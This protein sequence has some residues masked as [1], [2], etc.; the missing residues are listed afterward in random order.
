MQE[1]TI[2]L[3]GGRPLYE[4]IYEYLKSEI[5]TGAMKAADRLPSSRHLAEHLQVSR[6][7]VNMAYEQLASEG[8]IESRRGSGYFVTGL[9]GQLRIPAA[10]ADSRRKTLEA[11]KTMKVDFSPRGIDVSTFPRRTWGRLSRE[12][13]GGEN[14]ELFGNGMSQGEPALRRAICGYLHAARGV[15]CSEDRVV[16]GAGN[17]YLLMLLHQILGSVTVAMEN[18]T[19]K[20]AWRILSGMGCRMEPVEM[21]AWG[22][23]TD[24]LNRTEA[25]IVYVMPSHQYPTGIVMPIKR[26]MELLAWAGSAEGRFVI[27]D[28]YDSEFRYKGKP[29]PSLQGVDAA[30]RVIYLGT[31][32]RSIAPAIRVSYMVLPEQL[33]EVYREKCGFYA[34][35]VSRVDQ[36]ILARFLSEGYFERHLNK[37]RALYRNKH[38]ILLQSLKPL[39]KWFVLRGEHAG[40]HLLLQE[41]P[42]LPFVSEQEL[43]GAA[44]L[45]GVRVYGL[46]GYEI[47]SHQP[48]TVL[49][50][51]ANLSQ[52]EIREGAELL[53]CAWGRVFRGN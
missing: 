24:L 10:P 42:E 53:A 47:H 48:S 14:S 35:T 4:Q 1:L 2:P 15:N 51:Y 23:R 39:E 45:E 11:E 49:L 30:D 16:I 18:P 13:L 20:Q 37:A 3:Q 46:S 52:Q 28:D 50:G 34:S 25:Q 43:I 6:S 26:R 19:Y 32:S 5:Q 38:E 40:L 22:M 44:E 21:D 7:T 8:Y 27:E 29:I 17:E 12:V 36:A 31:F 9:E 41:R 33:A